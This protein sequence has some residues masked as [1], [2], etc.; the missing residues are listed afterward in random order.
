MTREQ[1]EES[2]I[3]IEAITWYKFTPIR[4]NI[5]YKICKNIQ[6][7]SFTDRIL[8]FFDK[9]NTQPCLQE[10]IDGILK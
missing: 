8:S 7:K 2:L 5:L 9:T 1:F 6:S 4:K 3:E 10:L